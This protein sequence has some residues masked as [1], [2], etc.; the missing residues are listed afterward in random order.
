MSLTQVVIASSSRCPARCCATC[1]F[2][3][4]TL[5]SEDRLRRAK[6]FITAG[7]RT[8]SLSPVIDCTFPLNEVV[9]A[10]RHLESN[11]PFGKIVLTVEHQSRRERTCRKW[12]C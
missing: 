1:A 3:E 12:I 5:D 4:L 6:H 7:L 10:H 9:D 2:T 11:T 8:G